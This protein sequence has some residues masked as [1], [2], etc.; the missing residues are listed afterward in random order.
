VWRP[1]RRA[2]ESV[3]DVRVPVHEVVLGEP[4]APHRVGGR[5]GG[6]RRNTAPGADP[7]A[8]SVV[9]ALDLLQAF[10]DAEEGAGAVQAA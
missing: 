9:E 4:A 6:S 1:L 2:A 5:E 3:G 10:P 7:Y 8:V